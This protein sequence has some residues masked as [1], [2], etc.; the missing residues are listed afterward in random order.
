MPLSLKFG[1]VLLFAAML[2]VLAVFFLPFFK[3]SEIDVLPNQNCVTSQNVFDV[4]GSSQNLLFVSKVNLKDTLKSKYTCIREIEVVKHYPSRLQLDIL[5]K[6]PVVKIEGT[7]FLATEDGYIVEDTGYKNKP[8]LFLPPEVKV[9][10]GEKITSQSVIF[11]IGLISKLLKSDFLPVNVRI[12][13]S[14][15]IAVYNQQGTV[16]IFSSK[17]DTT[18]QVD[19][20]QQAISKAKIDPAKI[21]KID[22]RFEKPVI[23]YK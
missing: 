23:T 8:V 14:E 12:I 7:N 17:E 13:S 22:L 6:E 9:V 19:S 21:A 5:V 16:A 2:I 1:L 18:R 15:N 10:V 4:L 11:A 20:L 3:L